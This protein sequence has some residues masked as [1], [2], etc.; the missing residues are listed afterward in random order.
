MSTLYYNRNVWNDYCN[1]LALT[2]GGRCEH[3]PGGF[4]LSHHRKTKWKGQ[5]HHDAKHKFKRGLRFSGKSF[6]DDSVGPKSTQVTNVCLLA[7][8]GTLTSHD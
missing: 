6:D 5:E 7:R 1:E 3:I 8:Y 4:K 2:L